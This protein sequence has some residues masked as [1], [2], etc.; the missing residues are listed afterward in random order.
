MFITELLGPLV[1]SENCEYQLQNV[2]HMSFHP[3]I[4]SSDVRYVFHS[5]CNLK[6]VKVRQYFLSCQE[7]AMWADRGKETNL[8]DK[9]IHAS[10]T[11]HYDF[12]VLDSLC[13]T[14]QSSNYFKLNSE[15]LTQ[16]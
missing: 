6:I 1:D 16:F 2:F 10:I 4:A 8:I 3:K 14:V 5:F 11:N 15:K 9:L 13:V 7:D 12:A